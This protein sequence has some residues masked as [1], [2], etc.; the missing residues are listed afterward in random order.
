MK[1]LNTPTPLGTPLIVTYTRCRIDTINYPDDGHIAVRNIYRI[2]IN[3]REKEL[4]FSLVIYKDY[5]ETHGQQ[6]IK[7]IKVLCVGE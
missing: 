7:S 4:C 2:E 5:N 3:I 6:Y 1:G